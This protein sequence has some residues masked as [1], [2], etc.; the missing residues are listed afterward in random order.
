MRP[1]ARCRARRPRRSGIRCATREPLAIGLNCALGAQQLRPYVEELS[2]IADTLRLRVSERRPAERVR[3]IRRDACETAELLREFATSGFVNIV[4]GCCGTTPEHI[5]H[6]ARGGRGPARRAAVP[7]LEQ[8][9]AGSARPRAAQHRPATAC[10]STSASAPTSPARRKFRKL[11]KADDYDGALD[12][13]R[14]QVANGAQIIDV[15][16]DEGMLDSEGA[17]VRFLNLI[18]A[19]P[20]IARVPVM[21]DS[22]KWSVIEAGL[23]CLQGK[24]VVN[25]IS[26]KEGEEPFLAQARKVRRYGAAVV[27]MA[28]DEQGQADTVERKVAICTRAYRLL[29]RAGRLPPRGHHLRSEHLRRRDRHRGA[30]PLRARLHRGDARD[31]A[32]LA[33]ACRSAAASATCRSRSAATIRCARR[34]TRCSCTTRSAPAWTWASS[35]PASSR[36][37]RRSTPELRER[38]EDVVLNRRPGC[39]RAPARDRRALQGR[40]GHAAGRPTWRGANGRSSK[41]LE[42]ALVQGIDE[43][44]VEDTEEARHRSSSVRSQVIEGPLMDGMNVVGDLFGAGKMFL[45]QV[46]KIARA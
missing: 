8:R 6:I 25:S 31:Q 11:I 23:K 40:G 2:R 16:M 29:T 30:R 9:D 34:C 27:V 37:T 26:L 5:E 7:A 46:V 33:R 32:P 21:I 39:D 19:E 1:A 38:V 18:A 36:S 10:S 41:R 42:H 24:G 45:P 15:N 35:T 28:F 13:A 20:D 44:I 14:Q 12:V 43:F 3:R 4:G 22:S 17:M